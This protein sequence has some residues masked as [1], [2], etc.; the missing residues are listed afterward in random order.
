MDTVHVAYTIY[1]LSKSTYT[2][3]NIY[4]FNQYIYIYTYVKYM[5][6]YILY[7]FYL[8]LTYYT[9]VYIYIYTTHTLCTTIGLAAEKTP[10]PLP[11]GGG[12]IWLGRGG[13]GGPCSYI[14]IYNMLFAVWN[15]ACI[16]YM[17]QKNNIHSGSA[18]QNDITETSQYRLGWSYWWEGSK[19]RGSGGR[20]GQT[21]TN[22]VMWVVFMVCDLASFPGWRTR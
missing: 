4:I 3:Y 20:A 13:C 21:G 17:F 9:Y 22:M 5:Y 18:R 15:V 1:I 10:P 12:T 7:I 8:Y 14:Y 11:R 2:I 6:I 16:L 19:L